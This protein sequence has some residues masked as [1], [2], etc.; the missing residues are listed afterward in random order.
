[1]KRT[2]HPIT[3]AV[4]TAF[5]LGVAY[6]A[7]TLFAGPSPNESASSS[8][9]TSTD[10]SSLKDADV[11]ILCTDWPGYANLIILNDG[12]EPNINSEFYKKF[13]FTV[14]ISVVNELT[15]CRSMFLSD[16][17]DLA[18]GTID[19]YASEAEGMSSD[20][21]SI[22]AATDVSAGGDVILS[23]KEI[24]SISDLSGKRIAVAA[25]SP[26][27]SYLLLMLDAAGKSHRD[28][29]IVPVA[30]P[31]I[32]AQYL[33]DGQADA[34]VTWSPEDV[35]VLTQNKNTK[36]LSS[37]KTSS[38]M[39]YNVFLAKKSFVNQK[40]EILANL[41]GLW[42][43]KNAEYNRDPSMRK[44]AAS[45]LAKYM[46]WEGDEQ[47]AYEALGNVAMLTVGDN[48]SLF[49]IDGKTTGVT[50]KEIYQKV[51]A[52]Y[53]DAG[54]ISSAPPLWGS[55]FDG[56]VINKVYNN[57]KNTPAAEPEKKKEFSAPTKDMLSASPLT[58][59]A[60]SIHFETG[61]Y[62]LD[63]NAMSII[64]REFGLAMKTNKSARV[65]IIGN[66]DNVGS[67]DSNRRLSRL[68]AQAVADYLAKEYD[69]DMNRFIVVGNGPDDALKNGI[70]GESE[71][72]R[73][74]DFELL[75]N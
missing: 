16:E 42:F 63:R 11:R 59:K 46:I 8:S 44:V 65:R 67:Q 23:R 62:K 73:R 61:S 24:N 15:D 66:T 53:L 27:H 64:D 32:A 47:A 7:Y 30:S 12:L 37:T 3:I 6:A 2:V 71:K 58:S 45:Y 21:V 33:I 56:G 75:E 43:E 72:Y 20:G 1:M 26:S 22:I 70:T 54:E 17:A 40:E 5:I 29:E 51:G 38:N 28:V 31:N 34:C 48:A 36:V 35:R 49:S 60:V 25:M 14:S 4:I 10:V 57:L 52:L 19:S 55:V 18:W 74:T 41:F 69:S 50:G 68:R 9:D 13:G 39:I